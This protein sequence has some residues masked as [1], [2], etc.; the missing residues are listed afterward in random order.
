MSVFLCECVFCECFCV[1]V[2]ESGGNPVVNNKAS[3]H[4]YTIH[5][6]HALYN[7]YIHHTTQMLLKQNTDQAGPALTHLARAAYLYTRFMPQRGSLEPLYRLHAT[8]S[9]LLQ[10]A[11]SGV[12]GSGGAIGAVGGGAVGGTG[13]CSQPLGVAESSTLDTES[14]SALL[15]LVAKHCF[16]QEAADTVGALLDTRGD[17]WQHEVCG[18]SQVG[19]VDT[20]QLCNTT[21]HVDM[22]N[23]HVNL[24][25]FCVG[26]RNNAPCT[27]QQIPPPYPLPTST[28]PHPNTPQVTHPLHTD[29]MHALQWCL[30]ADKQYHKARR[31]IATLQAAQGCT[32]EAL[33]TLRHCF[34]RAG[35]ASFVLNM[36]PLQ[37]D[38]TG[39]AVCL[40][41]CVV[42]VCVFV[43]CVFVLCVCVMYVCVGVFCMVCWRI[44]GGACVCA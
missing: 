28:H 36:A 3:S 30:D 1:C 42:C 26:Y 18:C 35:R 37:A 13:T 5:H 22:H 29:C 25:M 43:L 9:K 44:M 4:T 21:Q 31:R 40:C 17:G 10:R 19:V 32:Q 11:I 23:M 6:I 15:V 33:N 38:S 7:T 39:G 20:C 24:A 34:S 12:G 8:R 14:S 16:T 27:L 41:V 2:E